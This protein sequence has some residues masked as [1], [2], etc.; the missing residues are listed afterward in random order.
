V[1]SVVHEE[2]FEVC[3]LLKDVIVDLGYHEWVLDDFVELA[4]S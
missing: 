3:K 2:Q 4:M 1:T